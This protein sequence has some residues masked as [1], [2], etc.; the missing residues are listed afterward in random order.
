MKM[1]RII[2]VC[3]LVYFATVTGASAQNIGT[4]FDVKAN[5]VR[6]AENLQVATL[7]NFLFTF[8]FLKPIPNGYFGPGTFQAVKLYQKSVGLPQ[9]GGVYA[10]T[11]QAIK[12]ATCS[13]ASVPQAQSQ[14]QTQPQS[15]T[16]VPVVNSSAL[17][18]SLATSTP[19]PFT[20]SPLSTAVVATTS[21]VSPVSYTRPSIISVDKGTLFKG[22]STTWNVI[23][24]GSSF[25]NA[26]N[27][28]YFR[29][30]ESGRVY[31]VGLFPSVDKKTIILPSNLSAISFSCGPTCSDTLPVG[32]FDVTVQNEGGES[33]PIF[34]AIKGF[35]ISSTSGSLNGPVSNGTSKLL[36]TISYAS[37]VALYVTN[38]DLTLV[39]DGLGG[40]TV[41]GLTFKDEITGNP[42]TGTGMQLASNENESK[43]IGVYGNVDAKI[44]GTVTV[45]GTI[46]AMDYVGNKP[47]QFQVPSF[48]TTFIGY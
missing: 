23:I 11:R 16:L 2:G 39:T 21:V 20:L 24:N 42:I 25:S 47:V 6:G 22:A 40:G 10:L 17:T 13:T 36:G 28:V 35:S 9:T 44:G 46:T 37:S 1:Y 8:G 19:V 12:N 27:T 7:Q 4:C 15:T 34:I 29:S 45:Q 41:G 38:I 3:S 33:D 14:T 5:L 26:S 31:R 30:R 43:I 48:L 18:S 32:T